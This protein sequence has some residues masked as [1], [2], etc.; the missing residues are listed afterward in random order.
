MDFT[1]SLKKFV[2]NLYELISNMKKIIQKAL[3]RVEMFKYEASG[4]KLPSELV[5]TRW[6]SWIEATIYN[7]KHFRT[8]CHVVSCLNEN[9]ADSIKKAKPC[10]VISGLKADLAYIKSNFEVLTKAI[11][12]LQTKNVSLFG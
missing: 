10:I 9:D 6:G 11:I 1:E 7:C 4:I 2:N 3:Y 5:I 12:E 8:I